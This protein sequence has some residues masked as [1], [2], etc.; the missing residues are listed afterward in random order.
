MLLATARKP[1]SCSAWA[2]K[3]WDSKPKMTALNSLPHSF[4]WNK[5]FF[6]S[7]FELCNRLQSFQRGKRA[8][9][10]DMS[11]VRT[12]GNKLRLFLKPRHNSVHPAQCCGNGQQSACAVICQWFFSRF[13]WQD[14]SATGHLHFFMILVLIIQNL[15]EVK[16]KKLQQFL[17]HLKIL[18]FSP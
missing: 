2:S 1:W 15:P 9:L 18:P 4:P 8:C 12:Q 6:S 5:V 3:S 17:S 11:K 16:R 14:Y 10:G 7:A 13:K